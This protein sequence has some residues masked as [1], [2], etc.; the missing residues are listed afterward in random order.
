VM[1]SLSKDGT[2]VYPTEDKVDNRILR[3]KYTIYRDMADTQTRYRKEIDDALAGT[4]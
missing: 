3:T 2:V 1:T 4:R